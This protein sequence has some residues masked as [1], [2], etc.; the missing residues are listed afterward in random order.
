[1]QTSEP[2]D[3][4]LTAFYKALTA[5]E[6]VRKTNTADTGK[7]KYTY[8]DLTDVLGEVKRVCAEHDLAVFQEPSVIDGDLAVMTTLLHKTGEWVA[9]PPI[10]LPLLRDPQAVGGA[11]TYLRRYA[12]VTIFA[13]AVDDDDAKAATDQVRHQEAT[14]TRSGAEER[15]RKMMADLATDMP[16]VA[17]ELRNDFRAQFGMGLVDLPVSKHGE[18]LEW[19]IDWMKPPLQ[20]VE[21]SPDE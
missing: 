1:M 2:G 16:D 8:A 13:M 5:V 15:I 10:R 17:K 18:A 7:Y 11:I 14:G 12:L 20:T 4:A 3:K 6:L 19:V 9:F 21:D